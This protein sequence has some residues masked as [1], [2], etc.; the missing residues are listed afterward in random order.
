VQA[1]V[2]ESFTQADESTTR[3][4]GGTGLGMTISRQLVELMGGR[5]GL[6][7]IPGSGSSFW[8]ELTLQKQLV[9]RP[10]TPAAFEPIALAPDAGGTPHD[11]RSAGYRIL[12]AEDNATNSMVM[13]KILER[14]GHR[15]TLVKNGEEALDRLVQQ[16]FDAVALDMNMPVMSGLEAAKA[17]RF[18]RAPDTRAPIIMFSADATLEAIEECRRAGI[19]EFLPKPIQVGP[20]L[21][22][23]ERLVKTSVARR[24]EQSSTDMA[25][26]IP[27]LRKPPRDE[28]I[29]DYTTLAELEK[30]SQDHQ[31]LEG[32][33]A[34]FVQDNLV[35]VDRLEA[36]VRVQRLEECKEILHALKGSAVSIG[37]TAMKM[38][39][40]RFEQMTQE[41]LRRD[42]EEIV[43]TTRSDYER[44][45]DALDLYRG[46][47]AR[48]AHRV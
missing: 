38:T 19:D 10:D 4:Y 43:R 1:K 37:A 31:F 46:Q 11:I 45:C 29:L 24:R 3:R 12:I 44:L 28:A 36:S 48:T 26:S 16:D 32:L 22:A 15:C 30:I 25:F 5:I 40:Q 7:S 18:M 23:L 27:A 6:Q 2:F 34:G 20:F 39:C 14:A 41:E 9:S 21:D 47:R 8:F 42:A 17:Y 35:L 13:Q 33:L